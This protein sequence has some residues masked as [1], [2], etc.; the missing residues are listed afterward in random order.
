MIRNEIPQHITA[1]DINNS[2][3]DQ[4]YMKEMQLHKN[5]NKGNNKYGSRK[6]LAT[7]SDT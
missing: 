7:V 3:Y 4:D 5:I 6:K 1:V 2:E